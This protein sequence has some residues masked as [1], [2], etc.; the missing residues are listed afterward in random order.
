MC[1]STPDAPKASAA[2]ATETS[3]PAIAAANL[4]ARKRQQAMLGYQS[5]VM[6]SPNGVMEAPNLQPKT[7]IGV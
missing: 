1:F 2:P 6:S 5:T 7:L 3:D 4:R